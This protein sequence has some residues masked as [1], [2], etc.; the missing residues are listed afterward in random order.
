MTRPGEPDHL[1]LQWH[2]TDQCNLR[3]RHCYQEDYKESGPEFQHLLGILDQYEILLSSLGGSGRGTRGQINITGGEPFVRNDFLQLL[4]EI[5]GRGIPF[6][7]LTNGTLIDRDMARFLK[8]LAPRFIQLSLEGAQERHDAIRG[9]GNY[10]RVVKTLGFLKKAGINTVVSFT[11]QRENFRDFPVVADLCRRHGVARL[12]SDRLIPPGAEN[13]DAANTLS[14]GE[15][16]EFFSIMATAS[17]GQ[18]SKRKSGIAMH[19]ALQFLA[20]GEKPYRCNAGYGLITVMPDGTV[21]PCRRM[22]I[23]V[24]NLFHTSLAKIYRQSEMLQN[25]RD[26]THVCSGCESCVHARGCNGGLRC[27][28]YALTGDP[29]RADPGCWLASQAG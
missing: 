1:L 13:R 16:R 18:G 19:R 8:A 22:P 3:C 12:W 25:L 9:E 5:R 21:L 24:G 17:G 6:A 4:Q 29:F 10:A 2:I 26:P 11:A 14:P 28:A 23:P 20:T 15:A 7:I 27:L